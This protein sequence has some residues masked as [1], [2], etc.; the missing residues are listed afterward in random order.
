[1]HGKSE[2]PTFSCS[3]SGLSRGKKTEKLYA[4]KA[5]GN[6]CCMPGEGRGQKNDRKTRGSTEK[7]CALAF[8]SNSPFHKYLF[9]FEAKLF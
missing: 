1:V 5:H 3:R 9:L 7:D 6:A 8:F 2:N 4:Q